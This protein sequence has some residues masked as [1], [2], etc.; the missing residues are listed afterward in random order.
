MDRQVQGS[1]CRTRRILALQ[2]GEKSTTGTP[3][4]TRLLANRR[5]AI[6]RLPAPFPPLQHK[7]TLSEAKKD[8]YV[9]QGDI[10]EARFHRCPPRPDN[11]DERRFMYFDP[12]N[13]RP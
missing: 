13:W 8:T 2:G 1:S 4:P 3:C 9:T 10:S 11:P 6:P 7:E 12:K 5:T